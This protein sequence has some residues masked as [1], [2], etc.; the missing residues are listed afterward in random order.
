MNFEKINKEVLTMN[1]RIKVIH[2]SGDV[3]YLQKEELSGLYK[4]YKKMEG[5]RSTG[6]INL[7]EVLKYGIYK[8]AE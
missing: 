5:G 6:L 7:R 2:C 4:K 1:Q 8:I 3:Y